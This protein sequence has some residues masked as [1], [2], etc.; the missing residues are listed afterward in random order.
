MAIAQEGPPP[1][2]A[3]E[4]QEPQGNWSQTWHTGFH[5]GVEAARHDVQAGQPPDP[6][7]DERF[8]HPDAPPD[9]RRDFREGFRRGY[10]MFY[11]HHGQ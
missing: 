4:P 7:R 10:Q 11:D 5:E 3:W 9:Q 6:N 1:P 8:R 2:G